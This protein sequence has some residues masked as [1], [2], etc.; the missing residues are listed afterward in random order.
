MARSFDDW[1][2]VVHPY[3]TEPLFTPGALADLRALARSLPPDD[4][5]V[6]E[7]RLGRDASPVDLSIRLKE[8]AQA[9]R[10]AERLPSPP[11]RDFLLSWSE[12]QGPFQRVHSVWLEFDLD[13]EE[14]RGIPVPVVCA[15]LFPDA[16]LPWLLDTLFPALHGRPLTR[17]ERERIAFCVE[18]IPPPAYLLY[19]FSLRSR[20]G[21]FRLEVF[22]LDPAGIG[23]YLRRVAPGAERWTGEAAEIFEGN[24]RI[25]L[26]FDL[27]G[28]VLPRIGVEGSFTRRPRR[29]PG[30]AALFD[31]LAARGLCTPEKR[32]AAL[33][34]P[35]YEPVPAGGFCLRSLSHL[36]VVCRPD[37]ESEAKAYLAL[38]YL[39]RPQ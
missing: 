27:G 16:G 34:W 36:K 15:K 31:R 23:D 17:D 22:G 5:G 19:A 37:R 8:R 10:M 33:A 39:A 12:P 28:E 25:H 32:G 14:V 20:G 6:L 30:W 2:S 24:P 29:E 11:L 38:R 7:V 3:L 35:G 13:G 26:S 9:C 1:L 18:A 21:A 4:L